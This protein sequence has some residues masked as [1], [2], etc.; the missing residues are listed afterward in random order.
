MEFRQK[1]CRECEMPF[2]IREEDFAFYE[3]VS[4]LIKG[5]KYLIPPPTLCPKHREKRRLTYRNERNLYRRKSSL[6][7][8]E[9]I[10]FFH[11]DSPFIAYA[12]DEWWSDSWDPL[13]YGRPFDFSRS[14]F[15][16]F[17]ELTLKVPRPPLVN[18]KAE[19]SEYCNFTDGNKNCYLIISAD[20]NE[21]CY[22]GELMA[23]NRS[24]V[25]LTWGMENELVYEGVECHHCYN[26]RF[27]QNCETCSESAFLLNCRSVRNS[28]F[29]VN[30]RNKEYHMFNKPASKEEYRKFMQSIAGSHAQYQEALKKFETLK[31]EFPIRKANNCISCENVL[32]DNVVNSKNIYQGFDIYDSRDCAYVMEGL[33]GND[34]HDIAYYD[35]VQLCYESNSLIGYRLRF[36]NF[37]KNSSDILYCDNC[38]ATKN[39]F[40]CVGL[41]N[42]EYCI[43]NKQYMKAEYEELVPR[44]IEHM[45]RLGEWG[46]F[47]PARYSY[48]AYNETVAQDFFPLT[49]EEAR[50]QNIPWRRVSPNIDD[51][52]PVSLPD[53]I[54]EVDASIC[55]KI[56]TCEA[57]GKRY[58][59]IKPEFEFYKRMVLPLPRLCPDAR[60]TRRLA[61]RNPRTLFARRCA[62]CNVDIFTIYAP[63]RPETVYCEKCYL[64]AVY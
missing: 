16:Q 25:D 2:V 7:G 38:H 29:C 20:D 43:F 22:Y 12:H 46:E 37:C 14:F 40:G 3:A 15:E 49:E 26:V 17:S 56:L 18:N 59:I 54:S 35:K 13:S 48:F 5:E 39:C 6:S 51:L 57:T 1:T 21:D 63:D 55:D 10:S 47:F 19:N 31:K 32:G 60:Y 33:R 34:C 36:T 23:K 61:L 52:S 50:K 58:R 42:K 44:I 53:N 11:P 24:S 8:K 4:P 41:R 9:I 30:L 27:S 64:E 28:A 62:R 45:K